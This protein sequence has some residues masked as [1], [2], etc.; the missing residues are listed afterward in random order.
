MA[1]T[2][3]PRTLPVN[4]SI[5]Q[6]KK[7]AKELLNSFRAG[8]P[9]A[10]QRF[11]TTL[12]RMAHLTDEAMRTTRIKL[13]DAQYVIARGHGFESWPKFQKHVESVAAAHRIAV[14]EFLDAVTPGPLENHR[15][16]TADAAAAILTDDPDLPATDI[17]SAAAAGDA[18]SV[19]RML[20][21]DPKLATSVGG[22]RNWEPLLYLSFSRLLKD[23]PARTE[24]FLRTT[25]LLLANGANPNAFFDSN[26]ETETVLYGAGGVARN[27]ALVKLLLESGAN[28][29]DDD[30]E[31][32][33]AEYPDPS[34]LLLMIEHGLDL[35]KTGTSLL[36]KLDF[37][38]PQNVK[39]LLDAG[40]DPN[41]G[42]GHWGENALHQAII[43]GR[44]LEIVRMLI[45][46]GVDTAAK[47]LDGK[48]PYELAAG[49]GRADIMELLEGRGARTE[50]SAA[51][52]LFAAAVRGDAAEARRIVD[53]NPGL[54]GSLSKS[55]LTGLVDAAAR[56]E[57]KAVAILLD[58][59]LPIA[60][61]GDGQP[62]PLHQA[63]WYGRLDTLNLLLERGASPTITESN[64]GGTPLGWAKHAAESD[65]A[66]ADRLAPVIDRL[67]EAMKT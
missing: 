20:T 25:R 44:S 26:G 62:T 23:N 30:L 13:S 1:E 40:A 61:P 58:V 59:G 21:Q 9:S 5:E 12:L 11:R 60:G 15:M 31:Y 36:R 37:E 43:R 63:A 8:D 17:F 47:N 57:T 39:L 33:A 48:T 67:T 50:L 35:N 42:M 16:G 55:E 51:D 32:H 27:P 53:S 28:A 45:D 14:N 6:H 2:S 52:R 24:D 65:P 38:E 41:A 49:R 22:P 66:T 29:Q 3:R 56:G 4:P 34:C 10:V 19:E 7:Q 54:V 46:R 18:T 64:F